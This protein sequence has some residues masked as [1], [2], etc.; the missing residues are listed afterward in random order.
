MPFYALLMIFLF[1]PCS[2]TAGVILAAQ[3]LFFLALFDYDTHCLF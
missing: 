2:G 3:R 1:V